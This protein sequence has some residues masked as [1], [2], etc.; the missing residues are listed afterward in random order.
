MIYRLK[1]L[2]IYQ[3]DFSLF[4]QVC[5]TDGLTYTNMSEM[6]ISACEKN[7]TIKLDYRHKCESK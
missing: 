5:G 3:T 7:A 6:V 2:I 4:V 1:L